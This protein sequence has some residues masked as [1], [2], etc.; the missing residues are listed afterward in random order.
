MKIRVRDVCKESRVFREDGVRLRHAIEDGWLKTETI[1]VDFE[2]IRIASASF[3]DEGIAVLALRLPLDEIRK[4][5]R[6]Q[7]L[8]TPDRRLL[9]ELTLARARERRQAS[10]SS[11]T[12]AQSEGSEDPN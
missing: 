10:D 2:K 8:T 7:N 6:I 4:R 11:R 12:E 9:N 5:L 3:L 1:D